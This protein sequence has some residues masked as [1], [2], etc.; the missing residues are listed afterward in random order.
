MWSKRLGHYLLHCPLDPGGDWAIILDESVAMGSQKLLLIL[1]FRL[2]E[3]SFERPFSLEDLTPLYLGVGDHWRSPDICAAID[4]VRQRVQGRLVYAI[5]DQG[6]AITKALKQEQIEH[7]YDMKHRLAK[8]FESIYREDPDYQA[9]SETM[10]LMRRRLSLSEVAHLLPPNQRAKNRFMNLAP[11]ADWGN[12]VME[13]L[14]CPSIGL[15]PRAQEE[16]AWVQQY[17]PFFQQITPIL[18]T[19]QA[20]LLLLNTKGY[21]QQTHQL[22]T[23][24][25]ERLK[26]SPCPQALKFAQ[27]TQACLDRMQ[28]QFQNLNTETLACSSEIIESAFGKFKQRIAHN[29]MVGM[30]DLVLSLTLC[31]AKITPELVHQALE[32]TPT[33]LV[34]EWK[35]Q[36][37][38]PSLLARRREQL[39]QIAKKREQRK[40]AKT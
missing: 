17:R 40:G 7:L 32:L 22:A 34:I 18:E 2:D 39:P 23:Q 9:I 3:W 11:I 8:V 37:L 14:D 35:K 20:I 19:Q 31:F 26:Q 1:G 15:S 33:K 29:P 6:H 16:L 21:D 12:R 38:P 27:A 13:A 30:T 25:L 28:Q 24:Q 36:H 10:G 5:A 4:H